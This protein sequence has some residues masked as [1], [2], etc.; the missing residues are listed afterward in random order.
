MSDYAGPAR[1]LFGCL[2]TAG[3]V[4]GA[5]AAVAALW[6]AGVICA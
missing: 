4:V 1:M 5:L 3:I 6:L 2:F